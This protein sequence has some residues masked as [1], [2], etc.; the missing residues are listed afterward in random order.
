VRTLKRLGYDK[1][2]IDK[3]AFENAKKFFNIWLNKK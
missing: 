2:E 3:V 1:K